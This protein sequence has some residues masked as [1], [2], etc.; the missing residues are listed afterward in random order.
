[1]KVLKLFDLALSTS[2][3]EESTAVKY[4]GLRDSA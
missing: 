3:L 2:C 1:M 4:A